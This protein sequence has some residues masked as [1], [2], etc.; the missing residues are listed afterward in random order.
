MLRFL[1]NHPQQRDINESPSCYPN[2]GIYVINSR[3]V[4]D[5]NPWLGPGT[6]QCASGSR[7]IYTKGNTQGGPW[8]AKMRYWWAPHNPM[9]GKKDKTFLLKAEADA[10]HLF[11][12]LLLFSSFFPFTFFIPLQLQPTHNFN[13][14]SQSNTMGLLIFTHRMQGVR[15]AWGQRETSDRT[16]M[17]YMQK[18]LEDFTWFYKTAYVHDNE[19]HL[20]SFQVYCHILHVYVISCYLSL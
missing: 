8:S 15:I 3:Q 2:N 17:P 18:R 6:D 20:D 9:A 14:P 5:E 11:W 12:Q 7:L 13:F 16:I 10:H 4:E 1:L 19:V